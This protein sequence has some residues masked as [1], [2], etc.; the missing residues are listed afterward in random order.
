MA[1]MAVHDREVSPDRLS[2]II[3][4][5]RKNVQGK[6]TVRIFIMDLL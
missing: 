4:V 1:E 3:K 5:N 2:Q 6:C